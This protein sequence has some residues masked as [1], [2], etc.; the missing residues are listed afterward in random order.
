MEE[1]IGYWLSGIIILAFLVVWGWGIYEAWK[2]ERE[3]PI[4][5]EKMLDELRD[6]K[7]K[8]KNHKETVLRR[9]LLRNSLIRNYANGE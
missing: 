4:W 5:K 8:I 3:L 2:C 7:E 1:S 6:I 9:R